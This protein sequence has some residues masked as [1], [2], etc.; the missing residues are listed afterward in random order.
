VEAGEIVRG[1]DRV[2][3]PLIGGTVDDSGFDSAALAGD[4]IFTRGMD[5]LEQGAVSR[6]ARRDGRAPLSPVSID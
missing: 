6:L 5:P 1:F 3:P 2:E 4:P